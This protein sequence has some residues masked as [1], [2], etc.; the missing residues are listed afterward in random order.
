MLIK[1]V[2]KK[3][4]FKLFYLLI[5]FLVF[6]Y[7]FLL[8]DKKVFESAI[9]ETHYNTNN[10]IN[11][12]VNA[13]VN[14]IIQKNNINARDFYKI[15]LK[16][17]REINFISA[18]TILINKIC[19]NLSTEIY[20]EFLKFNNSITKISLGTIFASITNINLFY[21]L[22]PCLNLKL[23]P[24][25]NAIINYNSEFLSAGINQTN[26]R[27]W[28]DIKFIARVI[29]PIQSKEVIY[30]KKI[31]LINA[32]INGSVPNFSFERLK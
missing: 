10:I 5:I 8:I 27:I 23:V 15:D 3:N 20:E 25:G 2:H 9:L 16:S 7:I 14:N 26:F 6:F 17:N 1:K 4:K 31:A 12:C 19:N 18:N 28:L 29:T 22:G 21:D 32:I 24:V 30:K 11:K 13:S